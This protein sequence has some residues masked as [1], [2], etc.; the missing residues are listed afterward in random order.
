MN[1]HDAHRKPPAGVFV[2]TTIVVFF[3]SLSAADS[4]GFVPNY[5][6]GTLPESELPTTH[7]PD[8]QSSD[9]LALSQLPVLGESVQGQATVSGGTILPVRIVIS[10]IGVDLPVQNPD[11][12]DVNA[13]DQI[14]Q[15]GPARY[16][17]SGKLG[18]A[19]NVLIFAHSSHVPIVHNQMYKAFNRIPELKEGDT[20]TLRGEDGREYLYV[21]E[22]VRKADANDATIDLSVSQGT[23]LTL[24]TCDTLTSKSSRFILTT[25]FVG[26]VD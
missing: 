7:T 1:S 2:A 16:V 19:G 23:K 26:V 21:V 11:T 18:G 4:V 14:L 20:I 13:L 5:I 9:T 17:D 3:L 22:S 12:R 6:D 25:D 24:V 10:S 8:E 15:K